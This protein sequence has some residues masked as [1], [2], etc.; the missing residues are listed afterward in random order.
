MPP[1][2]YAQCTAH[3][4]FNNQ[5]GDGTVR[6]QANGIEVWRPK[7]NEQEPGDHQLGVD[8]DFTTIS[9]R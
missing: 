7:K 4:S 9:S 3:R 8:D 2:D 1:P 5:T 6:A